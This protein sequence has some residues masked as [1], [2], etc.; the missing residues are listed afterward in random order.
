[1]PADR[2]AAMTPKQDVNRTREANDP[3]AFSAK[4]MLDEHRGAG[5]RGPDKQGA[6]LRGP[7]KQQDKLTDLDRSK[8][9]LQDDHDPNE[10]AQKQANTDGAD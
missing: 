8:A 10:L 9:G 2:P 5:L 4:P 6:G 3:S 1:M 7:D